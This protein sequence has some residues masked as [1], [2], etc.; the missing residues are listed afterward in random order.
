MKTEFV[1]FHLNLAEVRGSW[2]QVVEERLQTRGEP[3]RWA[4]TQI[5]AAT[6]TATIE[7]VVTQAPVT[8]YD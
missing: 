3:L 7:A 6:Q 5:D 4:I 1:T 8:L 2:R